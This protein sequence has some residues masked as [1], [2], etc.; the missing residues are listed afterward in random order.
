MIETDCNAMNNPLLCGSSP[1]SLERCKSAGNRSQQSLLATVDVECQGVFANLPAVMNETKPS[2]S[3][4]ILANMQK[5]VARMFK[6]RF[7]FG[8]FDPES[9]LYSDITPDI[10]FSDKHRQLSLEAAEQ[11][12]VLLQNSDDERSKAHLPLKRGLKIAVVGPNGDSASASYSGATYLGAAS[13]RARERESESESESETGTGTEIDCWVGPIPREMIEFG[14]TEDPFQREPLGGWH[15]SSPYAD[16]PLY[17]TL[18]TSCSCIKKADV[19][20]GEY[21]GP[22]CPEQPLSEGYYG[23]LPTGFDTISAANTGGATTFAS[24]C[25]TVGSR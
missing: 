11:S 19:Y 15:A 20:F 8:E 10:I 17:A 13:E 9:T 14:R 4:S 18:T 21:H 16:V 5:A 7:Q 22:N 1:A 23:C 3:S 25:G 2:T 6:G 24:G 12:I